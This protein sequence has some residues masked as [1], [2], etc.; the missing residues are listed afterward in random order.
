M[1]DWVSQRVA[2]T[3]TARSRE[4]VAYLEALRADVEAIVRDY[5]EQRPDAEDVTVEVLERIGPE[6]LVQVSGSRDLK[7]LAQDMGLLVAL[8]LVDAVGPDRVLP[9]RGPDGTAV[10][11]QQVSDLRSAPLD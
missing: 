3:R 8:T 1:A 5:L 9:L 7:R 6:R 4:R 10:S 2:P 11:P